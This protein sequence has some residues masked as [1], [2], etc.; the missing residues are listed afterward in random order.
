MKRLSAEV[1]L[2]PADS[3]NTASF[4]FLSLQ[5]SFPLAAK[6]LAAQA[7]ELETQY[8]DAVEVDFLLEGEK[9]QLGPSRPLKRSPQAALKIAVNLHQEG[10]ISQ[11]EAVLRIHPEELRALL[12]PS[13]Q[14]TEAR[15]AERQ[16]RLLGCGEGSTAGV[17]CG[18]LA[19][20]SDEVRRLRKAGE[21]VVLVCEKL[22]YAERDVLTIIAGLIVQKGP[23]QA[24]QQFEKPCL[25]LADLR[26]DSS[27]VHLQDREWVAGAEISLDA[28]QGK[29]YDG[30][31]QILA[32]EL[33]AE[34]VTLMGW[35]NE[36]RRLEVRA[37]AASVDDIKLAMMF[38]AAGIGLFRIEYLLQSPQRLPVFQAALK[39]ICDFSLETSAA[40]EQL[41]T[42]LEEDIYSLLTAAAS[43]SRPAFTLR[44]LDAPLSH[45]MGFWRDSGTL[46]LD[47]FSGSLGDWLQELNPAQGLR[48]GRLS[49][50]FPSLMKLQV[51]ASLRAW[52]R[53]GKS[54]DTVL[55]Q[56]MMPG[57]CDAEELRILRDCVEKIVEE[58]GS[59]RPEIGSM[60]EV[61][62]AC[63]M[64]DELACLADFLSFGTGDLTESTCGISR[65]DSQLSFLPAYIEKGVLTQDPFRKI[66]QG[67]VAKLMRN[68]VEAVRA[69]GKVVELGT[70]GA[71]AIDPD[72]LSFCRHLGLKY[73]SVPA[74]HVPVAQ[75]AAAQTELKDI[76]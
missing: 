29:V 58:T 14:A 39:D 25:V 67:G 4:P 48:C 32:G 43:P 40:I 72:S 76:S 7:A 50:M 66:D 21:S 11:C 38:G 68:A 62:R 44:L 61:P 47:Y 15:R 22:T 10:L 52:L 37:N 5:Q 49:I 26:I 24:A 3:A 59:P 34:A 36:I 70:C 19:F 71:Q 74:H 57:V 30:S 42:E 17:T 35:A 27:G 45:M 65:Y 9:L 51:E 54:S 33:T 6:Q 16:G 55:L 75:L 8:C 20:N 64:A 53:A 23:T 12:L 31:L 41:K 28:T 63:L 73:V 13:F 46:P 1:Y 56:I 69:S 18:R 60:L 2:E